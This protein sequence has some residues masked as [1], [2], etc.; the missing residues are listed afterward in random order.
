MVSLKAN[1][2]VETQDY[3]MKILLLWYVT[4]VLIKTRF[5]SFLGIAK[6]V[7]D[8]CQ[9]YL[10]LALLL[11][12]IIFFQRYT[13]REIMNIGLFGFLL[14]IVTVRSNFSN[15]LLSFT[16]FAVASKKADIKRVIRMIYRALQILIPTIVILSLFGVLDNYVIY[17][18][19]GLQR[20]SLGF[21]HPN[22]LGQYIYTL[23][24]CHF[25]LRFDR[26]KW[27]DYILALGAAIFCYVVPNSQTAIV[28]L[29]LLVAVTLVYKL[30][31]TI[32]KEK[33][34]LYSLLIGA[35]AC[36]AISVILSNID[37]SKYPVLSLFDNAISSRFSIC[38][39]DIDVCG[40]TWFGQEVNVLS[41]EVFSKLG[42]SYAH[43]VV[44]LDNSYIAILLKY[45]IVMFAVF[46]ALFLYN[47][48]VQIQKQRSAIVILLF[49][50]AVYG[51]TERSLF[52]L[53]INI[54]LLSFADVFYGHREIG[55]CSVV[56][57]HRKV[58]LRIRKRIARI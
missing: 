56:P 3:F 24:G 50:T 30:S 28:L 20:Y 23:M 13:K 57:E 9:S 54:F 51:V 41:S 14:V 34:V 4:E 58:R 33:I 53:S 42:I 17:R 26:L 22:T 6:E 25:Y 32:S 46:S 16:L 11:I 49:L 39:H 31:Q 37:L 1:C 8:T 18:E 5:D 15:E 38:N 7:F 2:K 10:V 27:W 45:G 47:M 19:G 40:L 29:F 43:V 44:T 52:M 35:F 12:E 48:Y 36:N 21:S 55:P